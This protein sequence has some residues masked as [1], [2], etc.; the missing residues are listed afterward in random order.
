MIDNMHTI[1]PELEPELALPEFEPMVL[2]DLGLLADPIAVADVFTAI[3]DE[4]LVNKPK[5][6]RVSRPSNDPDFLR[7][8]IQASHMNRSDI[9]KKP[10]LPKVLKDPSKTIQLD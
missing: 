7:R 9:R 3:H 8:F 6:R 2:N 10:A 5:G 1:E 4:A